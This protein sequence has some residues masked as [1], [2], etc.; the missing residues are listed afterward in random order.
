MTAQTR[1]RMHEALARPLNTRESVTFFIVELRK[2]VETFADKYDALSFFCDWAL[3]H[4]LTQTKAMHI[5]S[6]ADAI[7]DSHF[8]HHRLP[9]LQMRRLSPIFDFS[10]F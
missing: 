6:E 2:A 7:V 10:K 3:H 5:L 8:T 1:R 9:D 4:K